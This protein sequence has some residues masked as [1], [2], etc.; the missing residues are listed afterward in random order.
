M[1][2]DLKPREE[3]PI[4]TIDIN[5]LCEDF[6][7]SIY[8][9][10]NTYGDIADFFN[11]KFENN[12]NLLIWSTKNPTQKMSDK[13]CARYNSIFEKN[14]VIPHYLKKYT[15]P[16]NNFKLY[17]MFLKEGLDFNLRLKVEMEPCGKPSGIPDDG[18]TLFYVDVE[19]INFTTFEKL[20]LGIFLKSFDSNSL[21]KDYLRSFI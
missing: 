19:G 4:S 12:E 10:Y 6:L 8:S 2:T 17:L 7:K 5:Q 1:R 16:K 14:D 9:S 3:N 13:L 20:S 21:M 11:K 18:I 15:N